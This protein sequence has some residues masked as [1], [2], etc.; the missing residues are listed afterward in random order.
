[1]GLFDPV[2][3]TSWHHRHLPFFKKLD[4]L[5]RAEGSA[6][7]EIMIIGPGGVTTAAA[8]LL[9]D[10]DRPEAHPVRKLLGDVARYSDQL[11]RRIPLMPLR[12]LEP[13]EV[14]EVLT[15]PH[16]LIVVD[17]S[18]RILAAIRH[19]IPGAT[20]ILSDICAARLPV[21]ADVIIA[22]NVVCRLEHPATGMS[23]IAQA[24]R[25][26][27]LLLMD[28]RSAEAHL[29]RTLFASVAPKTYRKLEAS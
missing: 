21:Q 22:F 17:R 1:M 5:L 3:S 26:G 4:E 11:L 7:P 24:L 29:D 27:G 28:D 25:G 18:Q 13:L 6:N 16:R 15:S 23:H 8:W 10:A 20:C 9:N 19:D 2:G 14:G 12:S